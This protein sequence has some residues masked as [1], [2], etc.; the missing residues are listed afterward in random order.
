M[1]GRVLTVDDE[2]D[3]LAAYGE[4]LHEAGYAVEMAADGA[5]AMD[6]FAERGPFDA[7]LTD[8]NMPGLDGVQLLRWVRERDLDVPVLIM[9]G[10]PGLET[11]VQ[12]LDHGALRYLLKPVRGEALVEAVASAIRLHQM[13]R[14]KREAL[15]HLG[16]P[17]R[18]SGAP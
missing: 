9:T 7:V 1:K 2:P 6:L 5:K 13:A 16:V 12:A 15:T 10:H 11:A 18:W 3:L 4:I 8:I 17:S 14:L